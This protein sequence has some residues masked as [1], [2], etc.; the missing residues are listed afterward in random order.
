MAIDEPRLYDRTMARAPE[1]VKTFYVALSEELENGLIRFSA[2]MGVR[3]SFETR[4][5]VSASSEIRIFGAG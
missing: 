4:H 3:S 1:A 5:R 2:G